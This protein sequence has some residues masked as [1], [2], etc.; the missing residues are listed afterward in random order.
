MFEETQ[1]DHV[2]FSAVTSTK[3][4]LLRQPEEEQQQ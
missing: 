2:I 3:S 4:P 1:M